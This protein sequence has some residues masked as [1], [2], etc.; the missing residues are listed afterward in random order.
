MRSP[1]MPVQASTATVPVVI[2][3]P[4]GEAREG[5]GGGPR[6]AQVG[7]RF[8]DALGGRGIDRSGPLGYGTIPLYLVS[9]R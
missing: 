4:Y 5:L 9:Q 8:K 1:F 6:H 2:R 3:G 7:K